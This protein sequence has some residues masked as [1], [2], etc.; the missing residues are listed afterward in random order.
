MA[1]LYGRAGRLT[2][3][4]GGFRP[5]QY[6]C[7]CEAGAYFGSGFSCLPVRECLA[8]Y[9]YEQAPPTSLADRVCVPLARCKVR[10]TPNWPRSWANFSLL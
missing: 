7:E 2:A 8:N 9:T 4:N 5:G 6:H 3:K 1:L 10:T